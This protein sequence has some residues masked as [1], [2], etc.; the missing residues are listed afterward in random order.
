MMS[1]RYRAVDP[2]GAPVAGLIDADDRRG[3]LGLLAGRGLFPTSLEECSTPAAPAASPAVQGTR[4]RAEEAPRPSGRISRKE[5]TAFT[6]EMATLLGATIPIPAALNG[7]GQEEENPALRALILDLA[8]S[9]RSGNSLSDAMS[10]YPRLFPKLYSSMVQV[11]EE[12]GALDRVLA[13]LADL[14]EHEDEIRGEVLG[15]VAYPV[16]VLGLGIVT[17]CVLLIF[18]L[19]NLFGMLEGMTD[20]LPLPTRILL[21]FSTFFEKEWPWIFV[22]AGLVIFGAVRWLRT[23]TGAI[24]KDAWKVK[25]PILGPV[26]RASA[27]GRF[28]RTLGTLTQSGVSLLPALEITRNTVGNRSYAAAI[29]QVAEETR[30]GD[31]LAAPLRKLGLFP[32]TLVQMIAVGEETGRLD[33]MLLRVA[34]MQ[35]RLVRGRSRTLISLLAPALILVIGVLVGFIVMALLLPI[36]QMSQQV[37]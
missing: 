12:A 29:D 30:G 1:F 15:A 4:S 31:S 33:A 10:A 17:T 36:F 26:F 2:G 11:G 3:A 25:L 13:D 20:A 22:G 16:F 28:A 8:A 23:P 9:V 21:A 6:R 5:I 24:L 35:E 27:L 32:P 18:V 37:R 14:L 19:P 7:L 34:A